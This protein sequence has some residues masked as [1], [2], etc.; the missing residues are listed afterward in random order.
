MGRQRYSLPNSGTEGKGSKEGCWKTPQR[1]SF[2]Q[3]P[4]WTSTVPNKSVYS[5]LPYGS[6]IDCGSFCGCPYTRALL[7][8]IYIRAPDHRK[9]P[10]GFRSVVALLLS[11][12]GNSEAGRL[13]QHIPQH[14][15]SSIVADEIELLLQETHVLT[16]LKRCPWGSFIVLIRE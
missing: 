12:A 2:T 3:G 7:F 13:L 15:S 10:Y 1:R 9:L 5:R 4:T 16:T 8:R 11:S 14:C 6:S